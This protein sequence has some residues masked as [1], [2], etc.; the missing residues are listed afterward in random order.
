MSGRPGRPCMP[1]GPFHG[2]HESCPDAPILQWR[3]A[4]MRAA[5]L[6]RHHETIQSRRHR[7]SMDAMRAIRMVHKSWRKVVFG[8]RVFNDWHAPLMPS[9][10]VELHAWASTAA[11]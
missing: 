10:P 1:T 2:N 4:A 11:P 6:N 9:Y 3:A 8:L 7:P 5:A